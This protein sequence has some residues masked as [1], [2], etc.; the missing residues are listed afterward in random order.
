MESL[1]ICKNTT[2]TWRHYVSLLMIY[3]APWP[4][5]AGPNSE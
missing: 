3:K 4:E 2:A 5:K 1:F